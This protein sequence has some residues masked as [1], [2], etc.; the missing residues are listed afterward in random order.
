VS[1]QLTIRLPE[2]MNRA[3]KAAS[4]RM[5]R[6]RS[7]IVRLALSQFLNIETPDQETPEAR[8]RHLIGSLDSGIPDLAENH[9]AYLLESLKRGG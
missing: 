8:V 2:D 5:R 3:L 4:A 1:D 6:R 7:E 9:R